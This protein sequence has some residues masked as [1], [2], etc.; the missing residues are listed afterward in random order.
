M[1]TIKYIKLSELPTLSFGTVAHMG[2]MHLADKRPESFEGRHL[3]VSVNPD[4]WLEIARIRG[5]TAFIIKKKANE[6]GQKQ[7][8]LF[9]DIQAILCDLSYESIKLK[10]IQYAIDKKYIRESQVYHY[11]I[12]DDEARSLLTFS[13]SSMEKCLIECGVEPDEYNQD[14]DDYN[15]RSATIYTGTEDFCRMHN[16]I[17]NLCHDHVDLAI[18]EVLHECCQELDGAWWNDELDAA[19]LSA[20]R[21]GLFTDRAVY[22]FEK[23]SIRAACNYDFEWSEED[24]DD[25]INNRLMSM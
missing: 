16:I 3:S 8:M 19:V 17:Y 14:E 21:G 11:D 7:S 24:G 25:E 6:H 10:I 4:A 5:D 9:V 18:V 23:M 20:P 2:A 15:I 12:F 1:D 22:D 13:E